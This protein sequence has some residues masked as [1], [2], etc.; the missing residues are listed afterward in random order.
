MAVPAGNQVPN[1]IQ[2]LIERIAGGNADNPILSVIQGAGAAMASVGMV[3]STSPSPAD[4]GVLS[5]DLSLPTMV[6]VAQGMDAPP[7]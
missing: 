1:M 5:L 4:L 3:Q 7:R 6:A 2:T